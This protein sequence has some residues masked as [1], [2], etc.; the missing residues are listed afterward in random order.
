MSVSSSA[1]ERGIGMTLAPGTWRG[2]LSRLARDCSSGYA[3]RPGIRSRSVGSAISKRSE[4]ISTSTSLGGSTKGRGGLVGATR[5]RPAAA[6]R[7]GRSCQRG[8]SRGIGRPPSLLDHPA[9]HRAV[10][11]ISYA[12]TTIR[13][14]HLVPAVVRVVLA[15]LVPIRFTNSPPRLAEVLTSRI[16]LRIDLELHVMAGEVPARC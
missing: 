1:R 5:N 4:R 3:P 16:P 13:N 14:A 11:R 10:L 8:R 15:R 9:G 7:S 2:A 12:R 6:F